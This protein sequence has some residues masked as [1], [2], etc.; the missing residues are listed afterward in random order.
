[1]IVSLN[2]YTINDGTTNVWL[3]VELDGLELP[4]IRTSQGNYAGKDG[5]YVGA[6][7][8]APRQV[9][10]Q[11]NVFATDATTF[12]SARRSLQTAIRGQSVTVQVTTNSGAAYILYCNLLDFKMPITRDIF[13]APFKIE[14]LAP[15]PTIYDNATGTALTANVPKIVSG[16]YTYP[17][18]Y[19]VIYA[20]GSSPTTVVNSGTVSVY[21]TITLSGI[22]TNPIIQNVTTGQ[23]FKLD[24]LTTSSGDVVVI[25]MR[26]RSVLLNG[27]SIFA[28]VDS[29]SSWWPLQAGNN[30]ISLTS[31]GGSDTVSAVVS[32]RSGYMGI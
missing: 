13:K 15:D 24:G 30:S 26:A 27:G 2:G 10:I 32:W 9:T 16:G 1:M 7:F 3:D 5:G 25:D 6:Q 23:L 12:E 18:V 4:N 31:S 19:P 20:A 14:L 11:G 17:V 21:P 22:M 28:D 8:Y 29:A